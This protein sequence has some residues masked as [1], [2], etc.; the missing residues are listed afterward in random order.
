MSVKAGA[1]WVSTVYMLRTGGPTVCHHCSV[2]L[3]RFCD[4][5]ATQG[6]E[7]STWGRRGAAARLPSPCVEGEDCESLRGAGRWGVGG[8]PRGR[9]RL[10]AFGCRGPGPR[11]GAAATRAAACSAVRRP[12]GATAPPRCLGPPPPGRSPR[13]ASPPL[14]TARSSLAAVWVC[15]RK[16]EGVLPRGTAAWGEVPKRDG[17][18]P[19]RGAAMLGGWGAGGGRGAAGAGGQR[20]GC[21]PG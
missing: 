16:R 5:A 15:G 13:L 12:A 7:A 2:L 11:V 4:A 10:L 1:V 19:R 18:A 17:A 3:T 9:L 6:N 8:T 14:A 20:A 21:G